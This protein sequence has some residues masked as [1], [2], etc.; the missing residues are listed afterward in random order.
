MIELAPNHKLGL[1]VQNPILLATQAVGYGDMLPKGLDTTNV[2]AVVVGPMRAASSG[3]APPP[4]LAHHDGGVV[5]GTGNYSRSV[6]QVLAR[7][8]RAWPGLG[9][10]VIAQVMDD[11]AQALTQAASRLTSAEGLS[12]LEW[13]APATATSTSVAIGVQALIRASDLPV[14]VKL[15]LALAPALAVPAVN[16]GA[17][18][19]VIGQPLPGAALRREDDGE[20][21][22]EGSVF[23]PLT[24]PPMLHAL[25]AV[26]SLQLP[27]ALIA[28]GGIHTREQ[29]H[30]ALAVGAAAVQLD[31]VVW[32]EPGL[33]GRLADE[34]QSQ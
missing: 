14:W 19:L 34:W 20:V 3:G 2:G 10:P 17:V 30:Q 8:A 5:L 23:G 11:H 22:I 32:V 12:G 18:G 33:V 7:H 26:A 28:C 29:V 4:R 13:W 15:P 25:R 21:A 31:S 16:A 1:P 24:F 27:C 6:R 9:C